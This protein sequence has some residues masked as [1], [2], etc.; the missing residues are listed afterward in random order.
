MQPQLRACS[1][2]WVQ[3]HEGRQP[4]DTHTSGGCTAGGVSQRRLPEQ[5]FFERLG[6]WGGV[7]P[8]A[9]GGMG[10]S[11]HKGFCLQGQALHLPCTPIHLRG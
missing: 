9:L 5:A 7:G 8:E 1:T 2:R 3:T 11:Q 10:G 4:V 6:E